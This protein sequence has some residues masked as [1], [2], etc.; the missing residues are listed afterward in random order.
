MPELFTDAERDLAFFHHK[1]KRSMFDVISYADLLAT[2]DQTTD[3]YQTAHQSI[4]A[5]P[6]EVDIQTPRRD[7]WLE[8]LELLITESPAEFKF[9][10]ELAS[11]YENLATAVTLSNSQ[12]AIFQSLLANPHLMATIQGQAGSGKSFTTAKLVEHLLNADLEVLVLA[13][14]HVA[15]TNINQLIDHARQQRFDQDMTAV[16]LAT[17]ND[18]ISLSTLTSW[19]FRLAD[20]N[21]AIA[22]TGS[23][24]D[25]RF[26]KLADSRPQY[27]LVL[28]DEAFAANGMA[29][30]DLFLYTIYANIP[31]ILIGDPN[32]LPAI[33]N[34][35]AKL[36]N[37][38]RDH[39]VLF[40][41]P[42]L[43]EVRRTSSNAITNFA[44]AVLNGDMHE[45]ASFYHSSA[46]A[47]LFATTDFNN[48]AELTDQIAELTTLRALNLNRMEQMFNE[49][50]LV[51]TNHVRI[52]LAET[53]QTALINHGLIA[54]TGLT[55]E[56]ASGNIT[57][58]NGDIIMIM[59]S[60]LVHDWSDGDITSTDKYRLRGATRIQIIDINPLDD[61][62]DPLNEVQPQIINET[63][64]DYFVRIFVP[65]LN[66][67]LVVNLMEH[68]SSAFN[69]GMYSPDIHALYLDLALG[70]TSTINKVQGLSLDHVIVYIDKY[71]PHVNRNLIY[72]AVTR[73]R[74]S[75]TVIAEPRAFQAGISQKNDE[76]TNF[77]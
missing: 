14:T 56:H 77:S 28:V 9:Q 41:T 26:T 43:S 70:Y 57:V 2:A 5:N 38:L 71:Y 33:N 20:T 64:T 8:R 59:G 19:M 60:Q 30:L 7:A 58:H 4:A 29:L 46:E 6:T 24:S 73:A 13:P 1:L 42:I 61:Y 39:D 37:Y 16:K 54:N 17:K 52:Q 35:P 36:F 44:R 63:I 18:K 15:S 75:D 12:H 3:F 76:F 51:P 23:L 53:I 62:G 48:A 22:Q 10:P 72:S 11:V 55:L 49:I 21:K 31:V 65:D 68:T 67:E 25:P 40:D 74:L 69:A 47:T 34:S 45:L 50:V 66:E 27:D 32:Q